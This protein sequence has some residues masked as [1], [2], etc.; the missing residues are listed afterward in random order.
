MNFF[1]TGY[2]KAGTTS[3]YG[4]LNSHP[5]VFLPALKEPHYFTEDYP[6]AREVTTEDDYL[7]LYRDAEPG[8]LRG[9]ASASVIHSEVALDRILSGYPDAKFIVLVREPVAA[10][11]SFHGELLHNLNEDEEV[12]ERA[13]RLQ[14]DRAEGR[15]IPATCREPRFLQY[16]Q[17]FRYRDQLPAFFDKVPADQRLV[18]VFEE[19]FADP[20]SGYRQVLGFLGLE[21]DGRAEFGATNSAR[22]H[23]FRWLVET[24]RKLV[25]GNG[26]M[27]RGLKAV[28][29]RLRIHPSDILTRFN[30]K[31]GG[32]PEISEIFE[33]ELRE[34][35]RPDVETAERLLG[36]RIEHWRH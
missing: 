4:Y 22:R 17:I 28:L 26:P 18:L 25:D 14:S 3:L 21:D 6:G 31:P 20:R 33:A 1:I 15:R 7:A 8:Q 12:F 24:H 34:H 16:E 19:F 30:R 11:R 23:R 13:W 2:P 29:S 36:R 5:G 9:D 35:F 10:V 27:Y 32:K